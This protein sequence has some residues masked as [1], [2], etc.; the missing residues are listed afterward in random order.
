MRK[1][2]VAV[3]AAL[4]SLAGSLAIP[5]AAQAASPT[6]YHVANG[7]GSH[8][9]DSTTDSA[10]IPYCTIQA[11]VDVATV[12][13][14]TVIV[15]AGIYNP[16]T[17]TASGTAS[18]PI[19][20][21]GRSQQYTEVTDSTPTEDSAPTVAVSGASYVNIE[22]L[23]LYLQYFESAV[24]ISNSNHVTVDSTDIA[25]GED[26]ISGATVGI[27]SSS[28]VTISR[29]SIGSDSSQG[30][31]VAQGGS[32]N[33][34]TANSVAG[35]VD[36]PGI[37]LDLSTDAAVT[38]NTVVSNCED[39]VNVIGGSTSASIENN[40]LTG[41]ASTDT[42]QS[43]ST[44]RYGLRVDPSSVTGT[45]A[46][47]N[48]IA[49][50]PGGTY[51]E[52]YSWNGTDYSSTAA[53]NTAT[54]QAAHDNAAVI[55]SAD[56]DAPGELL[57]DEYGNARADDP[58]VANTGV[59][60]YAYYDR[61]ATET[62]DPISVTTAASWPTT[63]GLNGAAAYSA[64]VT[65]SWSTGISGCVYDFGDGTPSASV[66]DVNGTCATP[67][68]YAK[69][70]PYT[71]TLTVVGNDGYRQS[72][73]H[74]VT[75]ST[76]N[77]LL[78]AVSFVQQTGRDI[79]AKNTGRASWNIVECDF[80]FGDGTAV[81][82]DPGSS[83]DA[84]HHYASIGKFPV[85]MTVKY[86]GGHTVS[87]SAPFTAG[88]YEYKPVTPIR[89]L[90]TRKAIG[91]PK[92]AKVAPGGTVKLKLTGVDGVPSGATAVTL[93]VTVTN[94][95]SGGYV[96]AYPD[97]V[98]KPNASNVNFTQG[99][100]VANLVTV[101]LGSDG[102]VDLTN[103]GAGTIDLVAD[104][105][106]YYTVNGDT[107]T[108]V[109]NGSYEVLKS[110]VVPAG[111]TV[112]MSTSSASLGSAAAVTLYLNVTHATAG[113][114]IT[115][116]PDKSALPN[117]SNVNFGA[118]QTVGNAATV[119]V[120]S[121]GEVD[122]TNSSSGS[123]DLSVFVYGGFTSSYGAVF[124]PVNPTRYLDTR[125]AIGTFSGD[126]TSTGLV[127]YGAG[128]LEVNGSGVMQGLVPQSATS[129]AANITVTQPV[130]TGN[131]Q[132]GATAG[133]GAA[134]TTYFQYGQTLATSATLQLSHTGVGGLY[135]NN[136]SAG[137]VQLVVDVNGYY[138]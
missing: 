38:S 40:V 34:I 68:T 131:L 49:S 77:V 48:N 79:T 91:V 101:K 112:T 65:D 127:A 134:L 133:A 84:V 11:A 107:Y 120:G 10:A 59:G 122:F 94:A 46:D 90:D 8:C 106:G 2:R 43:G 18:A 14:D 6:T 117:S 76:D 100:T 7:A 130:H 4:F 54:G 25:G 61:G 47:F 31:V 57:T 22:N 98:T 124:F 111:G 86:S 37:L 105:Q 15:G 114:F 63:A 52:P 89:V 3:T 137:T 1:R 95:S 69:S 21:E 58:Y 110:V 128:Q 33:V 9:S 138:R 109:H 121:D 115:A 102:Y 50:A 97:G 66:S 16:F 72:S 35:A 104:L 42:C 99:Q 45:T 92:I 103:S 5:V 78:P 62:V 30:A 83:C 36:G 20:I 55:D 126:V 70:G 26:L 28:Y 67:H 75:V 125:H 135:L 136:Q 116:Y 24:Q 29:N 82:T 44:S 71:I 73:T 81:A 74:G 80:N 85:T 56:S 12:P 32:N 27:T 13:G 23:D 129:V 64:A 19:T 41:G 87:V 132:V 17:V 60:T 118:G 93:N 123:V 113:G 39:A 88:G 53:F 108:A 96:T 51:I 119:A